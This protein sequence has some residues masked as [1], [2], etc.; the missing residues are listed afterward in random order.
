M[1][2]NASGAT[3]FA[4]ARHD[5]TGAEPSGLAKFATIALLIDMAFYKICLL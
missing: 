2:A 5:G 3:R 1:A 4:A